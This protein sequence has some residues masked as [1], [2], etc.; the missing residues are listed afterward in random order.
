[1]T[2]KVKALHHR[3]D[4]HVRSRR[5]TAAARA[6]TSTRCWRCGL[7]LDQHRPH[8][9]GKPAR[10]TA[11]HV[12]DG[13]VGGLLLPEASTCNYSAGAELGNQRSPWRRRGTPLPPPGTR[14]SRQW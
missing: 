9:N 4:Y 10:W 2:P 3:G 1:M 5:L 14:T 13:Q 7:T 8:R 11:G 6:D 12:N